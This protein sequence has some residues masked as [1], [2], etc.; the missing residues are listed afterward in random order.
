MKGGATDGVSS[1]HAGCMITRWGGGRRCL[2]PSASALL[3]PSYGPG[4]LMA[5]LRVPGAVYKHGCDRR[6]VQRHRRCAHVCASIWPISKSDSTTQGLPARVR[7]AAMASL[8]P[9]P[10]TPHRHDLGLRD[11]LVT[12]MGTGHGII[13]ADASCT[14][15]P[16]DGRSMMASDHG[17]RSTRGPIWQDKGRTPISP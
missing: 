1:A 15:D 12:T 16:D 4:S 2:L 3:L 14:P 8:S 13:R 6:G 17:S 7:I 10:S 11:I 5:H 9:H